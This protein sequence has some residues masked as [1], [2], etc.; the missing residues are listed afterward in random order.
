MKFVLIGNSG[1]GKTSLARRFKYDDYIDFN[2]STIGVDVQLKTY[3][4]FDNDVNVLLWDTAGQERFKS[5]SSTF[6]RDSVCVFICFD[7]TNRKSFD[8]ISN[9]LSNMLP[10]LPKYSNIVLVGLKTDLECNFQVS[11]LEAKTFAKKHFMSYYPISSKTGKN[12][13]RLFLNQVEN[14]YS[15][16]LNHKFE[17][18][19]HL[20][21]IKIKN[22]NNNKR[23]G[24]CWLY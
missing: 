11:E 22:K 24:Y 15:D 23:R 21:G 14:I 7:H 16:I 4:L 17:I 19:I 13:E 12:V 10:F 2:T 18:P 6:Y 9:W 8:D 1:I 3:H 5:I 20:G